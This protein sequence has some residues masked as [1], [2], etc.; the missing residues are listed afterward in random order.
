MKSAL[1]IYL[2]ILVLAALEAYALT[3]CMISGTLG[4]CT[5]GG[6]IYTGVLSGW[7]TFLAVW[8]GVFTGDVLTFAT[9]PWIRSKLTRWPRIERLVVKADAALDRNPL[10]VFFGFHMAPAMKSFAAVA[11]RSAGWSWNKFL[12]LEFFVSFLDAAWFLGFG[13]M[14]AFAAD[15]AGLLKVI[16]NTIAIVVPVLFLIG[17]V[18]PSKCGN[19]GMLPAHRGWGFLMRC[20]LVMPYWHLTHKLAEII[21]LYRHPSR[22]AMLLDTLK[23]AKPGDI[24]LVGRRLSPP[25]GPWS[26]ACMVVELPNRKLAMLHAFCHAGAGVQLTSLDRYPV[27][28]K[29]C[30]LRVNCDAETISDALKNAWDQL[31]K[32]FQ[33]RSRKAIPDESP[34]EFSCITFVSYCFGKAGVNLSAVEYGGVETP[35]D[36]RFSSAVAVIAESSLDQPRASPVSSSSKEHLPAFVNTASAA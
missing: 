6:A 17:C 10:F 13:Y 23:N 16:F 34:S 20:L 24:L 9:T 2:G 25:W 28:W 36:L 7:G 5:A 1:V 4:I 14:V 8:L 31:G 21:G 18:G 30:L 11:A 26:H 33:I 12:I 29:V 27:P 19:G 32:P 22:H 15:A 3:G 35:T